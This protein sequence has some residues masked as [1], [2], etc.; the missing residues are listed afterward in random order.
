MIL[1][2]FLILYTEWGLLETIPYYYNKIF[3]KVHHPETFVRYILDSG[4]FVLTH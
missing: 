4:N 3:N 1:I 2:L